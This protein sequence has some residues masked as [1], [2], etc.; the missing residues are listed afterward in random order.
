MLG[1]HLLLL[2]AAAASASPLRARSNYQV[3]EK[4]HVPR[5]WSRVGPAPNEHVINLQ[6]GLKQSQF[7]ELEKHLYQGLFSLACQQLQLVLTR[8]SVGPQA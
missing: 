4:F 5:S 2:L 3:K 7:D 8:G 1:S 6:I